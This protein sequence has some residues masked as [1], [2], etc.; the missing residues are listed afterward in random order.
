M[1]QVVTNLDFSMVQGDKKIL[2]FA[3]YNPDGTV[4]VLTGYTGSWLLKK[5]IGGTAL[6][7][8]LPVDIVISTNHATFELSNA[9]SV[10]LLGDYLHALVLTDGFGETITV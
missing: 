4:A 1:S 5:T 7:E 8:K 2:T 9:D 10:T 3:L 6:I